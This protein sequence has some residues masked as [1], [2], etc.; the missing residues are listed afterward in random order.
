MQVLDHCAPCPTVATRTA[1]ITLPME[2]D[3][4]Y[5]KGAEPTGEKPHLIVPRIPLH[6]AE[7][8]VMLVGSK[9]PP[10]PVLPSNRASV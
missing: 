8:V 6:E 10:H 4:V 1:L 9:Y 5:T 3:D 2:R 7:H